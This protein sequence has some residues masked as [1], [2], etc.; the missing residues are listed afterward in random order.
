MQIFCIFSPFYFLT[1][2]LC[3][4]WVVLRVVFIHRCLLSE[5][6]VGE[7]W[8]NRSACTLSVNIGLYSESLTSC[9]NICVYFCFKDD[10]NSHNS[11][12]FIRFHVFPPSDKCFQWNQLQISSG[13]C[14][15]AL[16]FTQS[17]RWFLSFFLQIFQFIFFSHDY[18]WTTYVSMSWDNV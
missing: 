2:D 17:A 12:L 9:L 4:V 7:G 15:S 6:T 16:V 10:G 14:C 18:V 1:T 11:L 5:G 8:E 3:W 13:N